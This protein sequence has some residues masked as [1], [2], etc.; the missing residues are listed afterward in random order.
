MVR[1]VFGVVNNTKRP[2]SRANR[3]QDVTDE[4][5]T[6]LPTRRDLHQKK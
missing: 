4:A 3:V 5:L 1:R 6:K 2:S